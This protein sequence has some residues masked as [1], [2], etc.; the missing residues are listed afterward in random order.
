MQLLPENIDLH[1]ISIICRLK[2]PETKFKINKD[3]KSNSKNIVYIIEYSQC[4]EIYIGS[5]QALNTR[6]SLPRSNI[7]IKENRK[8][9][10]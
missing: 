1:I 8:L 2:N 4:K 7:K 3:L 5:T 9:N 6:I 10:V